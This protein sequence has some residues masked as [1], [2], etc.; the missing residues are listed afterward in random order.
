MKTSVYF[1]MLLRKSNVNVH[2][3]RDQ[4]TYT[5]THVRD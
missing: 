3:L 1:Y 5:S 2:Y 4:Q